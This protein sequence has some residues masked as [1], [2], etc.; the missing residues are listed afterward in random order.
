[1]PWWKRREFGLFAGEQD[2]LA[3]LLAKA[4]SHLPAAALTPVDAI[5]VS[6]ELT[7]LALQGRQAHAQKQRQLTGSG[8]IGH[9]L[10]KDVQV[11]P[12]V[13]RRRQSSPSSPQKA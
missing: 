10:I 11:L 9:A 12:A 3:F 6:R 8:T 4:V 2:A 5:T 7:A 13:V 1:L